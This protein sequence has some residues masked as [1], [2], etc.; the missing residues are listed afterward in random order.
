MGRSNQTTGAGQTRQPV[1]KLD[2]GQRSNQT[3][4]GQTRQRTTVKLDNRLSNQTTSDG[5]TRQLISQNQTIN[6]SNQTA[7]HVK[8]YNTIV[9]VD[10]R[11]WH[12]GFNFGQ[13]DNMILPA[14]M[15]RYTD[16]IDLIQQMSALQ[17]LSPPQLSKFLNRHRDF[18]V[19]L[20]I[21]TAHCQHH[22]IEPISISNGNERNTITVSSIRSSSDVNPLEK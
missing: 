3:T 13:L 16:L 10:N 5:Q 14:N 21:A 19:G 18:P 22:I 1:V 4:E 6:L 12:I 8:V 15:K 20:V 7:K 9:K 17:L 2:N 11:I